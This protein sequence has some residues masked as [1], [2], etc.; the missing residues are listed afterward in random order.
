MR[1][2]AVLLLLSACHTWTEHP[3]TNDDGAG[4]SPACEAYGCPCLGCEVPNHDGQEFCPAG[5]WVPLQ[6]EEL[7]TGC[8][9]AGFA[10]DCNGESVV[11]TCCP[12]P[13]E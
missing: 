12:W 4:G 13:A 2:I 7:P 5:T 8:F 11:A 6:C 9:P 3:P 1:V 10:F